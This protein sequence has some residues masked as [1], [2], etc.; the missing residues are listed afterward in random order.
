MGGGECPNQGIFWECRTEGWYAF[1]GDDNSGIRNAVVLRVEA[2]GRISATV[3]R[4]C[5]S[6]EGQEDVRCDIGH[7]GGCAI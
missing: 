3:S 7:V 1:Q 4:I 2:V 6:R 5:Q